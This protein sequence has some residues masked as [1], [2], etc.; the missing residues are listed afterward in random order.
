MKGKIVEIVDLGHPKS[1]IQRE[2]EPITELIDTNLLVEEI[3]QT[4]SKTDVS[5][6]L[7]ADN[8]NMAISMLKSHAYSKEEMEEIGDDMGLLDDAFAY[9]HAVIIQLLGGELDSNA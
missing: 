6:A 5:G 8:I 3:N 2:N 9:D 1:I 4:L 7:S